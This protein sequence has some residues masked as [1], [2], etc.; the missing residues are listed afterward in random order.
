MAYIGNIKISSFIFHFT[1]VRSSLRQLNSERNIATR[2]TS[3]VDVQRFHFD[4]K[5][6]ILTLRLAILLNS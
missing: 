4:S 5:V 3:M 6:K 2:A 1:L